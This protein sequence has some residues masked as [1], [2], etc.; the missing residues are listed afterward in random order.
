MTDI[1]GNMS[2]T[3]VT[4]TENVCGIIFDLSSQEEYDSI[5]EG[6]AAAQHFLDGQ[7]VE[8]TS[9]KDL[10]DY[11]IDESLMWGLPYY[12]ISQFFTLAGEGQRLFVAFS[13]SAGKDM[14]AISSMQNAANG[15]IYQ[16]G[17]W[18]NVCLCDDELYGSSDYPVVDGGLLTLCQQQAEILGGKV[19]VT[20]FEGNSP[21]NIL[22][23]APVVGGI[24]CDYQR[25]PD[26]SS[27][28]M[29][30]ISVLLGQASNTATHALQLQL[31]KNLQHHPVV[32]CVG[33]ALA[34]L[35]K[36]PA[37]KSIGWVGGY[38]LSAVM[39]DAELGF[40][41][42]DY[43]DDG[44]TADTSFTAIAALGYV[45]RNSYLHQKGYI[46][47]TPYEGMEKGVFFSSDQ[48]LST[49]DYRSIVRCRVM[50]KSR[51]VVRLALLGWVN[52]DWTVDATTGQLSAAD[53]SVIKNRVLEAIDKNMVEPVTRGQQISGR[54]CE[55]DATQ[56]ILENDALEIT[57]Y[58]VP[59]GISMGIYV[60]EGFVTSTT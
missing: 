28:G 42:L 43:D 8:L 19:G 22:I 26:L 32:G 15:I 58:L 49:G 56:N 5:F 54:A 9:S 11:G 55:I 20:N 60:T 25:L 23:T 24:D 50:H 31:C 53:I 51:R 17:V 57:Y 18:T 2:T 45:R 39:T 30:K 59:R 13:M 6:S 40:G 4:S 12:H 10:D 1:T 21:V 41:C 44:W 3:A 7:V 48:T 36:A 47:L 33:A 38:N 35:A 29:E 27:M 34:M 16:I 37:N 52:Q 46:F 14:S